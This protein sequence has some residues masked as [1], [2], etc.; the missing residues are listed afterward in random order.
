MKPH[1][2]ARAILTDAEIAAAADDNPLPCLDGNLEPVAP[3]HDR[4][5]LEES[6][7]RMKRR[8]E[9]EQKAA[10][11]PVAF[12]EFRLGDLFVE[13]HGDDWRFDGRHGNWRWKDGGIWRANDQVARIA[14]K[15]LIEKSGAKTTMHKRHTALEALKLAAD[16]MH[17]TEWDCNPD[18]AGLPDGSIIDLRTGQ[19]SDAPS[20]V[21]RTLGCTP[22]QGAPE[23]WLKFL[24]EV[25]PTDAVEFIQ[26]W[27]GYCLTGHTREHKF[28]LLSGGGRNGKGVLM[29]ILE[30]L[31]AEYARGIPP[32]S[33]IGQQT[34]HLQWLARLSGARLALVHDTPDSGPWKSDLLKSLVAGDKQTANFM[35]QNSFT[36]TPE[37]KLMVSANQRPTLRQVDVAFC[38]RLVLIP[39]TRQFRGKAADRHLTDTLKAE[40][41]RIMQWA[42]EG[43]AQWYRQGL[44]PLPASAMEA[45]EQYVADN[46][47]LGEWID[48]HFET[49]ADE[50]ATNTEIRSKAKDAK[51]TPSRVYEAL[52]RAGYQRGRR[53]VE[54]GKNPVRGFLNCRLT[55]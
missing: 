7:K 54:V 21:T 41:P 43:A 18:I 9:R 23:R 48:A 20:D 32:G 1:A 40:L 4:E 24:A 15:A 39:S 25:L 47:A 16:W 5:F 42:L 36:F 2:E 11:P 27:A 44:E 30:A 12:T 3:H 10:H 55:T 33:L 17:S 14:I 51:F 13:E 52:E 28:L 53:R 19:P 46:D 22:E 35:R 8:N 26:R 29:A 31:A 37:A 34:G 45:A 38:E 50:F 6:A 49:A